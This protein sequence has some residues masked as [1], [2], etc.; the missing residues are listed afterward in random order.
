MLNSGTIASSIYSGG[1][2]TRNKA[3]DECISSSPSGRHLG[4]YKAAMTCEKLAIVHGQLMIIPAIS[5]FSPKRWREIIKS[6]GFE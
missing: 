1:I 3:L 6:I 5:D 2:T 4:H